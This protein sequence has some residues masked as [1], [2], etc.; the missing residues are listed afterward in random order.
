MRPPSHRH[1]ARWLLPIVAV[2]IASTARV[3]LRDAMSEI[4]P[5]QLSSSPR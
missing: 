3:M 5:V 1:I 4:P 2:G